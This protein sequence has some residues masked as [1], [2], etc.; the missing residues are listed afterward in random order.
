MGVSDH[1]QDEIEHARD[2]QVVQRLNAVCRNDRRE[3][4]DQVDE[5][6]LSTPAAL[7]FAKTIREK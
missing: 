2:D 7:F 1:D 5:P 3:R 6:F 4:D